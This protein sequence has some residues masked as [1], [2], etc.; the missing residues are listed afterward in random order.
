M[1]IEQGEYEK[2]ETDIEEKKVNEDE[3]NKWHAFRKRMEDIDGKNGKR[4]VP[5]WMVGSSYKNSEKS[6]VAESV[7]TL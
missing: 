7:V 2:K 1:V 6:C 4:K 3:D 5:E